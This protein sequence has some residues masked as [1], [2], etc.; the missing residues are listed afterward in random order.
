MQQWLENIFPIRLSDIEQWLETYQ[1]Y[2]PIP[3]ILVPFVESFLPFLPL[4]AIIITNV[5]AYGLLPGFLFSWLGVTLG[6]LSV[7]YIARLY[8]ARFRLFIERKH[9][10]GKAFFHWFEKRGFSAIFI[11]SCFPFSPSFI[12]NI[13]SGISNI[14]IRTFAIAIVAGKGVMIFIISL[15][16]Q[17][18]LSVF[19]NPWR[20]IL[21]ISVFALL[22]VVGKIVESKIKQ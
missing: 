5:T 18:F 10:K 21:M 8:Q 17:D 20:L 22:W 3:G 2:G 13:V 16:G 7:F 6:A 11:F 14:S 12:I 1:S 4:I 15:V 9:P 19:Y